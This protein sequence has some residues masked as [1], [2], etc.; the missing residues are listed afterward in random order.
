MGLVLS[1]RLP[2]LMLGQRSDGSRF[3]NTRIERR[4]RRGLGGV[5]EGES[6]RSRKLAGRRK[7]LLGEYVSWRSR[8]RIS[9]RLHEF[10]VAG[11]CKHVQSRTSWKTVGLGKSRSLHL[12]FS[13]FLRVASG[14]LIP[15]YQTP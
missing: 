2:W 7:R 15:R 9:S 3:R 8:E 6:V 11:V 14:Y 4:G 12:S 1:L 13:G 10:R 5:S